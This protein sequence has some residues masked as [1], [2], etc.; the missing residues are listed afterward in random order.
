V[1]KREFHIYAVSTIDEGIEILS[2]KKSGAQRP[3]GSFEPGTIHSLVNEKLCKYAEEW[4]K[5]EA[6]KE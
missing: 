2:G 1:R 5:F 4:K 6:G 3:D